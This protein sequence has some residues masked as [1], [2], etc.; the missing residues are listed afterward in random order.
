MNHENGRM[1]RLKVNTNVQ[2]ERERC[3]CC[4]HLL[5]EVFDFLS[6]F[7][8][9]AEQNDLKRAVS[10]S[11][12]TDSI[13]RVLS[14]EKFWSTLKNG[15]IW[16]LVNGN[17]LIVQCCWF[18]ANQNKPFQEYWCAQLAQQRQTGLRW[19]RWRWLDGINQW[20]LAWVRLSLNPQ[21]RRTS[22]TTCHW[23]WCGSGEWFEWIEQSGNER[24]N[25]Q[26][27]AGRQLQTVHN[28]Q[29]VSRSAGQVCGKRN[30]AF[31]LVW[32]RG[33]GWLDES[34]HWRTLTI[35]GNGKH[36]ARAFSPLIYPRPAPYQSLHWIQF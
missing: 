31:G 2:L 5:G 7:P 30:L 4:F 9:F 1:G 18:R 20:W 29:S 17:G 14:W 21:Y 25:R 10:W 22:T 16:C 8:V 23:A 28:M 19:S 35:N 24:T 34:M 6:C 26:S 11:S 3:C 33:N 32:A 12:E 36:H 13:T 27:S 15:K